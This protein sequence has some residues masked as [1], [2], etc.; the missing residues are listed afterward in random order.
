MIAGGLLRHSLAYAPAV[1]ALVDPTCHWSKGGRGGYSN[2]SS[3]T[4]T[5]ATI[6]AGQ[7]EW[8]RKDNNG[9]MVNNCGLLAAALAI[10]DA[11]PDLLSVV[12]SG[13]RHSLPYRL[14]CVSNE[15]NYV[16]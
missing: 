15:G 8:V 14:A 7:L 10:G 13:L 16:A 6:D 5:S 3:G 11:H 2:S 12:L 1:Y 9:N 4:N